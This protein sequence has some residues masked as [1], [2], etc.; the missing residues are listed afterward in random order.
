MLIN[1]FKNTLKTIIFCDLY[2]YKYIN[3]DEFY[4]GNNILY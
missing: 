1:I 4:F 3:L 2:T